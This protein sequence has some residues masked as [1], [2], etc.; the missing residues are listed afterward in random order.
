MLESDR[1]TNK[2]TEMPGP[3]S[4]EMT[5]PTPVIE[6][7]RPVEMPTRMTPEQARAEYDQFTKAFPSGPAVE[8]FLYERAMVFLRDNSVKTQ[9]GVILVPRKERRQAARDIAKRLTK[10]IKEER[11]SE[12][13]GG[14]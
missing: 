3:V 8:H 1:K 4:A 14:L 12:S 11:A 9:K 2:M 6:I 10:R 5:V 13:T 7:Q